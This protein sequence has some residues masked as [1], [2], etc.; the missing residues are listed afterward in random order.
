MRARRLDDGAG[1]EHLAAR[2]PRG[3]AGGEVD[4][5]PVVVAVAVERLAVVDPDARQRA[6]VQSS[7]KPT[8]QSVSAAGS[9][10]TTMT[11]SPIVLMIRASSGSV[12]S[13]ASTKR[14]TASTASSSPSSSVSRV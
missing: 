10:P 9:E 2:G 11:S 3:D 4:L 12:F 5:A 8:A 6:L 13:T 1:D 14:S 7:W